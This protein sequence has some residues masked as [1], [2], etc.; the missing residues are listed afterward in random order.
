MNKLK[1]IIVDGKKYLILQIRCNALSQQASLFGTKGQFVGILQPN[2]GFRNIPDKRRG[3]TKAMLA[4]RQHFVSA[5]KRLKSTT[6]EGEQPLRV[7]NRTKPKPGFTI[8][9]QGIM[10]PLS[11]GSL[12]PIRS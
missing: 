5:D 7:H 12:I 8:F 1:A 10:T 9:F 2:K 11:A 4:G 6:P 3:I